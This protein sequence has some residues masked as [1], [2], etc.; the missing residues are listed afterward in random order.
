M[1]AFP[2]I[3]GTFQKDFFTYFQKANQPAIYIAGHLS[4]IHGLDWNP[5]SEIQ[6]ATSSQDCT[7]KVCI[8]YSPTLCANMRLA[9]K[10]KNY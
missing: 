8:L 9:L 5:S 4:K 7:V 3:A 10:M 6:L 2:I 1:I